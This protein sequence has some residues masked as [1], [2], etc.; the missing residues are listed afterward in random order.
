MSNEIQKSSGSNKL[1]FTSFITSNAI[2]Q[3]INSIVG[4]ERDGAKFV[5]NIVASVQANPTLKECSNTSILSCA[6]VAHSL[7][8][9]ANPTLGQIYMIP[10]NNK[11][12]GMKEA[13][14]QLSY[15]S[16][17]QLAIRSGYYKKINAL[18]IKEGELIKY[19]PLEEEIEVKLIDDEEERE[20]APISGFYAMFEYT[21]GFRKSIYWS[22]EKM[23]SHADKYSQSFNR[24]TMQDILNGKVAEKDMWKYSSPWYSKYEDMGCKTVLKQ[25]LSKYG[26]LSIEMQD[27]IEKD[28][29]VI[30]DDGTPVYVDN[31]NADYSIVDAEVVE[32]KETKNVSLD[33][34]D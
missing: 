25:L 10:F 34:L 15:K 3:K 2:T 28:Q 4:N 6:L 30:K 1:G 22:N 14:I 20:K 12:T 5:A 26:I 17:I 9:S 31:D 21:N 13:Q 8:L 29:A 32:K 23:L 19:D 18:A 27:A 24:K 33:D 7:N 11:N 16:Y